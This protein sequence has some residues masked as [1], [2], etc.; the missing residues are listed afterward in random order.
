MRK[1]SIFVSLMIA[2]FVVFGQAV[3][4]RNVIPVA[5]NL[6]QVLRMTVK[7]GGNIEF[8]FNDIAQYKAG[9]SGDAGT[10]ASANPVAVDGFYR[11]N[12]IV[13]SSTR[14]ALT[15]GAEEATF[16][17]TDDPG[18]TLALNNV[19]FTIVNNGAHAFEGAGNAKATT[20]GAELFSTPTDNANEVTALQ[21]YPVVIIEDNDDATDANAGD[22]T[23]NDF[24]FVWRCGTTEANAVIAGN[25]MHA[26]YLIDQQPSPTP[27]RYVVNVLF[28]LAID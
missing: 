18:N 13:A 1:L 10:S 8:V 15:Y 7:D 11:T 3:K 17:G 14:W 27:D 24:T 21:V 2:T 19:G 16:I 22:E 28:E 6:N 9:L 26:Q 23:D 5:V 25:S 4:D 12:F 20:A